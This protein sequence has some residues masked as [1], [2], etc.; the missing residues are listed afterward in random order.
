MAHQVHSHGEVVRLSSSRSHTVFHIR[1]TFAT[2][3]SWR[4]SA[5]ADTASTV[6]C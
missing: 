2:S 4:S 1:F 3:S 5:N 6:V